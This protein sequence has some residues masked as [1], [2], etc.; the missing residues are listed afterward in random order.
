MSLANIPTLI[1]LDF[2][3]VLRRNTSPLYELEPVLVR[4]LE[5]A[6]LPYTDLKVVITS[7]WREAY[8]TKRLRNLFSAKFAER[9]EGATPISN[10][11][12]EHYRYREILAYL[13][14]Y[15][16][17]GADWVAIDDDPLHFPVDSPLILTDPSEG[18]TQEK[19]NELDDVLR[20]F[21][22]GP[23]RR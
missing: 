8:S 7:S 19:A 12:S 18:F 22:E 21:G 11:R 3:G 14:R 5:N 13:Q 2:D 16:E 4:N 6:V 10:E 15:H 1:F 9:I 17:A 20:A 23:E